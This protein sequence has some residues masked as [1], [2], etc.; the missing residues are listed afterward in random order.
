MTISKEKQSITAVLETIIHGEARATDK[1]KA[2]ESLVKIQEKQ[3]GSST[4]KPWERLWMQT[5][6]PE[7]HRIYCEDNALHQ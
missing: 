2:I 1:V 5:I 6:I 4:L 3:E 7:L